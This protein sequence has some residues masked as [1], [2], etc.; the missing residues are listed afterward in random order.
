MGSVAELRYGLLVE[1]PICLRE[2][3][4]F[5]LEPVDNNLHWV[6]LM[7]LVFELVYT[8]LSGWGVETGS[9]Y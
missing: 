7:Y 9:H 4:F 2:P 1:S 5:C 8:L 6:D 3:W